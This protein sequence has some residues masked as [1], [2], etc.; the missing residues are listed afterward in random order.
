MF[1]LFIPLILM[2][3]LNSACGGGGSSSSSVAATEPAIKDA[4]T[5]TETERLFEVK[6]TAPSVV[7]SN[8]TFSFNLASDNLDAIN[9]IEVQH[10]YILPININVEA[11]DEVRVTIPEAYMEQVI[12][13][14]F[15]ISNHQSEIIEQTHLISVIPNDKPK[16]TVKSN[17]ESYLDQLP[18]T[19]ELLAEDEDEIIAYEVSS[20]KP[21]SIEKI[22][23]N[24]F[25]ISNYTDN[26]NLIVKV[27]DKFGA[28]TE[29]HHHIQ[30][31]EPPGVYISGQTGVMPNKR[32]YY[33]IEALDDSVFT[34]ENWMLDTNEYSIIETG[35]DFIILEF[36]SSDIE[37]DITLTAQL[38]STEQGTENL[39]KKIKLL[40]SLT[41]K[42]EPLYSLPNPV[43]PPN[44]DI[45]QD[46]LNEIVTFEN[47]NIYVSFSVQNGE[48]EQS[49]HA[50]KLTLHN[51]DWGLASDFLTGSELTA[52]ELF[53][54]NNDGIADLLFEG[55]LASNPG[56]V[57]PLPVL[58]WV[59]GLENKMHFAGDY[60][61][62][63]DNIASYIVYSNLN[64]DS[65]NDAI[66]LK[67][68]PYPTGPFS[69]SWQGLCCNKLVHFDESYIEAIAIIRNDLG[70][71][72]LS[73]Y[74]ESSDY[75]SATKQWIKVNKYNSDNSEFEQEKI[76][77]LN[78]DSRIRTI[79]VLDINQDGLNEIVLSLSN[80]EK[81]LLTF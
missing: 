3:F 31:V 39:S 12:Q 38:S 50:G 18:F 47:G 1:K 35:N 63:S 73:L 23:E 46:G 48:Y 69:Q 76:I 62:P 64:G 32:Y 66:Y 52:K 26:L 25:Q 6:I 4:D 80:N 60:L 72:L 27:T 8:Q 11:N 74:S 2:A 29:L 65:F 16:I 67:S 77:E 30:T 45:N 79:D 40:P 17:T 54:M 43:T 21:I 71:F 14:D 42:L 51:K 33:H 19:L 20:K 34:V 36:K 5:P 10:D 78:T 37:K 61:L 53:D 24:I 9:K 28:S 22:E 49:I 75:F 59:K 57:I 41:Y 13:F 58:G 68:L 70:R 55:K 44:L 56:S 81:L 7:K 15:S